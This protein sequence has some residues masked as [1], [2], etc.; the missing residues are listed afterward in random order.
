[1]GERDA[2]GREVGEDTLA[3]LGWTPS[4][5]PEAANWELAAPPPAQPTEAI[6]APAAPSP[7]AAGPLAPVAATPRP[8][9]VQPP[10]VQPPRPAQTFVLPPR[11]RRRPGFAGLFVLIAILVAGFIGAGAAIN[12]GRHAID[13]IPGAIDNIQA[14]KPA[15]TPQG[16]QT[17]SLLRSAALSAALDRLPVGR[18]ESLRVAPASITAETIKGTRVHIVHVFSDGRLTDVTSPAKGSADP[19][20]QVDTAAPS[21]LLRTAARRAHRSSNR[22]DYLVLLRVNRATQWHLYFDDGLHYSA[23]AAGRHVK[24]VGR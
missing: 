3:G 2:F 10:R 23:D 7:V 11:R 22:V 12:A 13:S 20:L 14:P 18:L 5:P 1:V 17:G 6:P 4:A 24:R 9:A 19:A 15:P 8:Q 16:V 21:R